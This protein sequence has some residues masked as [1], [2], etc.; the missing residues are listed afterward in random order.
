M[1]EFNQNEQMEILLKAKK[2]QPNLYAQLPATTKISV[3]IYES[4]KTTKNGLTP[5]AKLRLSGLRQSI[6]RD[7]LSPSERTSLALEIQNLEK[8]TG[9]NK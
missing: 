1:N 7:V 3:G 9:E 8:N 5:E 2:N 6:A 4:T